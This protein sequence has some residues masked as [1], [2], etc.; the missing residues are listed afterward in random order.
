[1]DRLI[2]WVMKI[3]K[4]KK[5]SLVLLLLLQYNL[6]GVKLNKKIGLYK[7]NKLILLVSKLSCNP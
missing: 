7:F 5:K 4:W 3:E 2:K 6:V 1:M